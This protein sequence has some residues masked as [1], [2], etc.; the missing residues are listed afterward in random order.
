[1]DK[2]SVSV[3]GCALNFDVASQ[4]SRAIAGKDDDDPM[5]ICWNDIARNM[6]SPSGVLCEIDGTPGWEVYGE[7]HGG[8]W[9]ISINDDDYVF[10]YA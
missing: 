8:R 1:M 5:L 9:R 4:I 3:D 7:N 10:I 6:H 2:I